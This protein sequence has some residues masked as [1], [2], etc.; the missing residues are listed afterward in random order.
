MTLSECDNS[1]AE[2]VNT[3]KPSNSGGFFIAVSANIQF[4]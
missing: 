4:L 3:F 2:T 1:E